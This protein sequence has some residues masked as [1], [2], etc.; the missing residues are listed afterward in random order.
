VS[1]LADLTVATD[2]LRSSF[3]PAHFNYAFLQNQDRHVHIHVIPRY[4]APRE[5]AGETFT[6]RGYP[7]HYDLGEA[8]V[9]RPAVSGEIARLIRS[10]VPN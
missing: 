10:N 2:A 9:V 7:G 6:D 8:R 5:C 4:A 1:L 3:R